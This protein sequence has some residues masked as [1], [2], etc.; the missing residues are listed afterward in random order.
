M[1]N[2][3]FERIYDWYSD[4]RDG[5]QI[6][7]VAVLVQQL[8]DE[9]YASYEPTKGPHPNFWQRLDEWL[10][11]RL[12]DDEQKLLFRLIPH[13]FF[14]GPAEL[15]SLYR[16]AFNGPIARWIIDQT[17]VMFNEQDIEN[18]LKEA[19]RTTWF[20]P[21]T[22]SFRINA[23][24]HINNISGRDLR[25]DWRTLAHFNSTKEVVDFLQDERIER[26][27][28]LED[29]VGSGSQI[30]D[31]VVFASALPTKTPVLV[32]PLVICPDGIIL[33][34]VLEKKFANLTF[35]PVLPVDET[36]CIFEGPVTGEPTLYAKLRQVIKDT[37]P[38]LLEGLTQDELDKL[39]HG[40]FGFAKTGS[41]IVLW[42]NCPD[43][44]LP[45]IHQKSE[46]WAPLF[47]RASRL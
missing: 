1:G 19:V 47:P 44:T 34:K 38:L 15:D 20:C 17:R 6:Q 42:T 23:F 8:A 30:Y 21:I 29:F 45:L 36:D 5:Q 10:N 35:V 31:A 43:N 18:T 2:H 46:K 33:G 12:S 16:V 32:V 41:L 9:L 14:V 13:I 28:L 40:P 24:Y 3:V 22:D 25:S 4:S 11:T 7:D 39:A 27:V 37:F 26:I